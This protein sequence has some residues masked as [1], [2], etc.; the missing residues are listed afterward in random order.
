MATEVVRVIVLG[1]S[2]QGVGRGMVPKVP[3]MVLV[4][5]RVVLVILR[6]VLVVLGYP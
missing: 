2:T 3:G 5:L 4:F 6:M 1:E